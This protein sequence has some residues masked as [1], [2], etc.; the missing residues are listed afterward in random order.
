VFAERDR[1]PHAR[2]DLGFV[3][4]VLGGGVDDRKVLLRT[5]GTVQVQPGGLRSRRR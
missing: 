2:T 5:G 1:I 4:V 3:P